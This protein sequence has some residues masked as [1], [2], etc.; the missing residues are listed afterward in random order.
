[1]DKNVGTGKLFL[2]KKTTHLPPSSPSSYIFS[3]ADP[4]YVFVC[5]LYVSLR[6]MAIMKPVTFL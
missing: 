4:F 6:P 5:S 1:M 2:F 3:R